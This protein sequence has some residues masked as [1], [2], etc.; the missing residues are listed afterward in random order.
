[1]VR[2]AVSLFAYN[3]PSE[4]KRVEYLT[5]HRCTAS[6]RWWD[7]YY[8]FL[9]DKLHGDSHQTWPRPKASSFHI[10]MLQEVVSGPQM[11]FKTYTCF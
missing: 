5:R 6:Y 8:V 7:E 1:M 9:S 2:F 4:V 10:Y 11:A 3:V